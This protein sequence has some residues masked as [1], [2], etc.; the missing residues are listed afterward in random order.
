[1]STSVVAVLAAIFVA[2]FI[3]AAASNKP[4]LVFIGSVLVA[5][6]A[7]VLM[8]GGASPE[9]TQSAFAIGWAFVPTIFAVPLCA[10]ATAV[11]WLGRRALEKRKAKGTNAT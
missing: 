7:F 2:T 6:L 1:M 5:Y 4:L 11:G 10:A 3:A 8:M 9:P